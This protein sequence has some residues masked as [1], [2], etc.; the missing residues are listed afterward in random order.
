MQLTGALEELVEHE[1]RPLLAHLLRKGIERGDPV[2]RLIGIGV[3]WKEFEVAVGIEHVGRIVGD[4]GSIRA[5][6]LA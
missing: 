1:L 4:A 5:G 2:L 6:P 3:G